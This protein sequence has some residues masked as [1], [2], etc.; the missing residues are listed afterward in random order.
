M[1]DWVS[2]MPVTLVCDEKRA[3]TP[4][5]RAWTGA[6]FRVGIDASVG[7]APFLNCALGLGFRLAVFPDGGDENVFPRCREGFVVISG[8]SPL[9]HAEPCELEDVPQLGVVFA[10]WHGGSFFSLTVPLMKIW[11]WRR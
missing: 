2:V 7:H 3:K 5:S 6:H 9:D 1:A 10:G 4:P 11:K 8:A